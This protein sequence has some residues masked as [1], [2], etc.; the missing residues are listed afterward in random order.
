MAGYEQLT[1]GEI[2]TL[3]YIGLAM[4]S[5]FTFGTIFKSVVDWRISKTI[6]MKIEQSV[7]KQ[8]TQINIWKWI[9]DFR[10]KRRLKKEKE[11]A[12]ILSGYDP[13]LEKYAR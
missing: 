7:E 12:M 11:H 9:N 4:I 5:I 3:A 8:V 2:M 13:Q 1:P 6:Q 10:E